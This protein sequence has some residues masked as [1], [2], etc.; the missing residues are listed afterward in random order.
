MKYLVTME[1]D[2]S[3]TANQIPE[4]LKKSMENGFG[5]GLS[6]ADEIK[7]E[8]RLTIQMTNAS[9]QNK[10]ANGANVDIYVNKVEVFDSETGESIDTWERNPNE[11]EQPM[12]I[13]FM[14]TVLPRM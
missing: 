2:N 14:G 10:D 13:P 3:L 11:E 6:I 12:N 5:D 9:G 8:F 4:L 1:Y 7:D